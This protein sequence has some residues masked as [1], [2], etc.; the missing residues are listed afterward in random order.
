MTGTLTY[1]Q[2]VLKPRKG[3]AQC[4]A[5]WQRSTSWKVTTLTL[6]T[7]G[8]LRSSPGSGKMQLSIGRHAL[9]CYSTQH[10]LS[11]LRLLSQTHQTLRSQIWNSKTFTCLSAGPKPIVYGCRAALI[12]SDWGKKG[13][14]LCSAGMWWGISQAQVSQK[15]DGE[16]QD[17]HRQCFHLHIFFSKT[18]GKHI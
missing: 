7:A 15:P 9:L 4:R 17:A 14:S 8:N 13:M 18:C 1:L 10:F 3:T 12:A 6:V 5:R 2:T 11:L 16:C